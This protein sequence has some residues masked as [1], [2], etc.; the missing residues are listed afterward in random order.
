MIAKKTWEVIGESVRGAS[1][2]R[3]N[4]ANQD[5]VAVELTGDNQLPAI[6]VVS[7]GHGSAKCVRSHEGSR[8]AVDVAR[9][10]LRV[11][12]DLAAQE[13][14][15]PNEI[16]RQ[17]RDRLPR[18]IWNQWRE[19]VRE[20][21]AANPFTDE[22]A[23]KLNIAT[24]L[25]AVRPTASS[26]STPYLAYGATLVAVLLGA[27]EWTATQGNGTDCPISETGPVAN[28][29]NYLVSL[30]LGDGEILA[31]SGDTHQVE[32]PVAPDEELIA[33]ETTS[34]CQDDAPKKFRFDFRF[35]LEERLPPLLLLATDGYPNSF[36]TPEGFRQVASDL[37]SLLERDGVTS[38]RQL[39]PGWL[40]AATN[41][42][43]GDDVTV[44]I[45]YLPRPADSAPR[46]AAEPRGAAANAN[47]EPS[48]LSKSESDHKP[49]AAASRNRMLS[50]YCRHPA[51]G[52]FSTV[53][54]VLLAIYG[55]T[56]SAWLFLHENNLR[57]LDILPYISAGTPTESDAA[58]P[59]VSNVNVQKTPS[60]VPLPVPKAKLKP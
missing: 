15:P 3:A 58:A 51:V 54:A 13:K 53:L 35:L 48:D 26:D 42:G 59:K 32:Q 24:S 19:A 39:L 9:R 18:K 38:V 21:F 31:I 12:A 57:F 45:L 60:V 50:W 44:A 10:N 33:N 5:A 20:H 30:Q 49:K 41:E 27:V 11:F 29:G 43:S 34:L 46:E 7:D 23:G 6:L 56:V 17:A 47:N 14:M 36:E 1:H 25:S 40:Q 52:L 22:E 37:L 4:L 28:R 16:H 55:V 8:M 2:V